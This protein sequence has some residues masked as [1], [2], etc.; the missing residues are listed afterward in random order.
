M[1]GYKPSAPKTT[2][3]LAKLDAEDESLARWKATLG[4]VPGDSA[5][6]TGPKVRS[7]RLELTI[8]F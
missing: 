1:S 3:E 7:A 4:I 6:A 2:E 5:P 8:L